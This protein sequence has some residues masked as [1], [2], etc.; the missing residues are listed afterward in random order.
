MTRVVDLMKIAWGGRKKFVFPLGE[1]GVKMLEL[2]GDEKLD[3]HEYSM[4]IKN[5]F[6]EVQNKETIMGLAEAALRGG[7]LGFLDIIKVLNS[8]TAKE[9]EKIL[10]KSIKATQEANKAMQE[11]QIQAQQQA[12]Q[13]QA[14]SDAQKINVMRE[15]NQAKV[16]AAQVAAD[17]KV[18]AEKVE[19]AGK[20][21]YEDHKF[22][23]DLDRTAFE[24]TAINNDDSLI[25]LAQFG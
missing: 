5:S 23:R 10:E 2:M 4:F 9:S 22:T 16:Q 12:A 8:D 15:G 11:Q 24:E 3:A 1:K 14:E 20:K 13:M 25:D 19:Q 17:G 18:E 21:S 6:K 7:Q